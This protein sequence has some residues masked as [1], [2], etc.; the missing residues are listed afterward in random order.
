MHGRQ[1]LVDI[2]SLI[3]GRAGLTEESYVQPRDPARVARLREALA[4]RAEGP[5]RAG[6]A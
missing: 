5:A 2:D 6:A 1:R 4:A 3:A